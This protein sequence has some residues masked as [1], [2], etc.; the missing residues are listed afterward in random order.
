[1]HHVEVDDLR[2]RCCPDCGAVIFDGTKHSLW[3][4]NVRI[5]FE[6]LYESLGDLIQPLTE[7]DPCP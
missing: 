4:R 6:A 2:R 3:H 5:T 7:E 1:M